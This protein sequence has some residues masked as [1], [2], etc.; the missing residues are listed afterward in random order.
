M[1]PWTIERVEELLSQSG[2]KLIDVKEHH[3]RKPISYRCKCGTTHSKNR[4]LIQLYGAF[5]PPCM[6]INTRQK[7]SKFHKSDLEEWIQKAI[8]KH[9]GKYGYSKVVYINSQTHVIIT[10]LTCLEEFPC[11]PDMHLNP[12]NGCPPCGVRSRGLKRRKPI[13]T[14]IDEAT[15]IFNGAYGYDKFEYTNANT[16]GDVLCIRCDVYF[17][18]DPN[19]HLRGQGHSGCRAIRISESKRFTQEYVIELCKKVHNNFFDYT[20][21]VYNGS[22]KTMTVMC[23]PHGPFDQNAMSHMSGYNGCKRCVPKY[24]KMAIEWLNYMSQKLGITIQHAE[25]GGEILIP[26]TRFKADGF[27]GNTVFEFNGD[28]WHGNPRVFPGDKLNVVNGKTMKELYEKTLERKQ[29]IERLGYEYVE[30]WEFDWKQ[31]KT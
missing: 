31:L 3:P 1:P 22:E 26:G 27:Y 24:S 20:D 13:E 12:G 10:C 4:D 23:P 5:C 17:S 19:H 29:E 16:P 14:F 8:K 28:Y 6:D 7:I 11:R 2:A 9:G 25:N 15:I 30:M 18:I 21:T